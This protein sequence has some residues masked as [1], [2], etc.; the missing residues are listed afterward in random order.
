MDHSDRCIFDA[1]YS[2]LQLIDI[3]AIQFN[4]PPIFAKMGG[5]DQYVLVNPSS[6]INDFA[7]EVELIGVHYESCHLTVPSV[8]S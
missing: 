5:S 6:A 3:L 1:D 4:L 8:D 7:D 2:R